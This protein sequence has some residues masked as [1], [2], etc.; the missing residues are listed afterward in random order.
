M[1]Y[2]YSLNL[3]SGSNTFPCVHATL[4]SRAF[5]V[6]LGAADG[7]PIAMHADHIQGCIIAVLT[8][9][10]IA[11]LTA[12]ETAAETVVGLTMAQQM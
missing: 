1:V 11:V 9:V 3:E 2:L 8:A 6:V 12:V 7:E 4:V 5:A 10:R